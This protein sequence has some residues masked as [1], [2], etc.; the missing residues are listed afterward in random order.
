[1]VFAI[2]YGACSIMWCVSAYNLSGSDS[3]RITVPVALFVAGLLAFISILYA[4]GDIS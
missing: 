3:E 1:M 4:T 2:I